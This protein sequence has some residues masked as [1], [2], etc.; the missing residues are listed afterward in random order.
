M[1]AQYL[2]SQVDALSVKLSKV[3][4]EKEALEQQVH[5][6]QAEVNQMKGR[7]EKLRREAETVKEEVPES[8]NELIAD[9]RRQLK[10]AQGQLNFASLAKLR[11]HQVI[12]DAETVLNVWR[13]KVRVDI[14]KR[15][16][17]K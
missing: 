13:A 4:K 12:S 9:L 10:E 11:L 16:I 15:Y 8:A 14:I 5:V 3:E 7:L 1:L 17:V 6:L 2:G